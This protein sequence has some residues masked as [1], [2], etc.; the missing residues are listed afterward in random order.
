MFLNF[1]LNCPAS[2]PRRG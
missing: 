1:V 2:I